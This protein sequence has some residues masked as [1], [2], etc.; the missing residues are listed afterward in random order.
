[1]AVDR[2]IRRGM[3]YDLVAERLGMEREAVM[4]AWERA[5]RKARAEGRYVP[6]QQVGE[7]V[8]A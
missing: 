6:A 2:G 7:I 4:R 3:G 8:A 1:L 5:K